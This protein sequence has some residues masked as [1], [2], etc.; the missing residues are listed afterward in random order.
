M[1]FKTSASLENAFGYTRGTQLIGAKIIY[2]MHTGSFPEIK[3]Q[4]GGDV[5]SP[6]PARAEVSVRVEQ[7]IYSVS[8]PSWSVVGGILP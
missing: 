4:G 2:T 8:G 3:R 7:Y 5:D 1:H 6:P